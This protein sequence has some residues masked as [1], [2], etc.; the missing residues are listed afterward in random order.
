M[1][2]HRRKNFT[3]SIL[4]AACLLITGILTLVSFGV[5][6]HQGNISLFQNW[7]QKTE[8]ADTSLG[9]NLILVNQNYRVP[10]DYQIELTELANGEKVDSRIYPELQ[11]MFDDARASGLALFVREGYRTA[12]EQQ[13]IMDERIQEYQ[14]EGYSKKEA[15]QLAEQ[16][17][18]APGTSEHEL[19]LSVDI[20]ADTTKCSSDAVYR[21]LAEHGYQY[22]FVKRY[23]SNKTEITGINEEP[24]HYRYVGRE[25]AKEMQEKGLCLE[26]YVEQL[27]K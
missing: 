3:T 1:A 8:E 11:A 26:E 27:S 6:T 7:G 18:A 24:W 20:N 19:G 13:E 17:V 23:P 2:R 9:W 15:K 12:Q 14:A 10:D 4:L 21:W 25:A 5:F 16:Y 22:G